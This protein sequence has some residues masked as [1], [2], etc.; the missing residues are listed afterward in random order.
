MC[1]IGSVSVRSIGLSS[2]IDRLYFIVPLTVLCFKFFEVS[3]IWLC[4]LWVTLFVVENY[5]VSFL[6]SYALVV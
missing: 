2:G 4:Q 6:V 1:G 5:V 3:L